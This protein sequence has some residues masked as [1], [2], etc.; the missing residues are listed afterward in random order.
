MSKGLAKE[1][2]QWLLA[3]LLVA[4]S[5]AFWNAGVSPRP[6]LAN[7]CSTCCPDDCTTSSCPAP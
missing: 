4:G 5:M 2:G 6:S 3:A 7:S 1:L